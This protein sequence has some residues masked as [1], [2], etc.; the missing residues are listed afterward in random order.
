MGSAAAAWT[1]TPSGSGGDP[2]G[3]HGGEFRVEARVGRAH[4]HDA[5]AGRQG[6]DALP[7]GDDGARRLQAGDEGRAAGAVVRAR[8]QQG[9]GAVDACRLDPDQHL[10]GTGDRVGDLHRGQHLGSA[11]LVDP[12]GAHG[13]TCFLVDTG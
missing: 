5:L 4:R 7:H 9:V 11:E 1:S 12:Y 8:A 10:A 6:V 13:A 2:G 3:G